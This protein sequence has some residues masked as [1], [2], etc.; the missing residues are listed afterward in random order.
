M[1]S[2][3]PGNHLKWSPSIKRPVTKV[4]KYSVNVEKNWE[5]HLYWA[6]NLQKKRA[7]TPRVAA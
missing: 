2:A 3:K 7:D 1:R 6:A 4:P 5:L